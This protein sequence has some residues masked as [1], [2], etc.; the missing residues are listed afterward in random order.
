MRL[1]SAARKGRWARV[2]AGVGLAV[3]V[4]TALGSS[5]AARVASAVAV[6]PPPAGLS[7]ISLDGSVGL[8]WQPVSGAT[9]YVVYRGLTP[10]TVT[11]AI[12]P[13]GGTSAVSFSDA[14]AVNGTSY[15]Y[16][17]TALGTSGESQPSS[18]A[19]ATP[20]ARSC[21]TGNAIAVE[22]CF[23]GTSAWKLTSPG[24]PPTGIEGYATSTSV[25]AGQSVDLK[26]NTA[27]GAPYHIE[28]Y[29]TGYYG[30]SEARLISVLP[31]LTGVSQDACQKDFDTGL[32]DCSSW[33]VTSTISTTSAWPTGVY[34]L[35]LVR[36]DNGT[37][38]HILLVVWHDGSSSD[39][40]YAAPVTTYEA[41]N[42]WGGRSLYAYNSSGG[43]TVAGTPQ[44]VKVS[45][46]RPFNQPLNGDRNWYTKS[47][48]QN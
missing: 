12:T 38:Y 43:N 46:D 24:Q 2:A 45:F 9:G 47:D 27:A 21:S 37:D 36:E 41:Y 25:N 29:R 40:F 31:G 13:A 30:G 15:Y 28:I 7:A 3:V 20:Q 6:P 26:V 33:S 5:T 1:R 22:N 35:R 18:E 19:G 10:T 8:A 32:V 17:V 48:L 42:N 11:T 44:A 39:I 4:F 16:A 14:G 23:P 34:L